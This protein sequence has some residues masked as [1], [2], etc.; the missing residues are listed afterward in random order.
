MDKEDEEYL[1]A[2]IKCLLFHMQP[3]PPL[4]KRIAIWLLTKLLKLT[5]PKGETE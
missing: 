1:L 3:R 4:H 2:V 5:E